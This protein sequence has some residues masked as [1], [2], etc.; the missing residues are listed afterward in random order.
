M[1]M[2]DDVTAL[3]VSRLQNELVKQGVRLHLEDA[4]LA[5]TAEKIAAA[6]DFPARQDCSCTINSRIPDTVRYAGAFHCHF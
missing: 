1:A 6:P 3:D 2:T 4:G 5:E